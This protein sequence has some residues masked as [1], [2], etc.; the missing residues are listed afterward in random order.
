MP[1]DLICLMC[2]NGCHLKID[3][4][5]D[6][7]VHVT[8][9]RCDKGLAFAQSVLEHDGVKAAEGKMAGEAP[10]AAGEDVLG[11]VAAFWG[12]A[13]ARVHPDMI[14]AG[15]PERTLFRAVIEDREGRR[16][17]LEQI[18]PAS[19]Q[20][21]MRIVKTLEFL[22]RR[23][24]PRITPYWTN[25]QG[26]YLQKYDNTLW[27]MVPFVVGEPLDRGKYLFEGWRAKVLAQFLM[28]LKEKSEGIPFFALEKKFSVPDYIALLLRQIETRAP[29]LMPRITPV[30]AFLEKEFFPA[31]D[32]LPVAFCHGDYHPMNI[33]WGKDD[34]RTVIDWEF[35]GMKPEMYDLANMTGCL[36]VEDPESLVGDLV[37]GLIARLRAAGLFSPLSFAHFPEFVIALRFAWLSEWLRKD[38]REMIALE[39]DY[40]ELLI[41][42]RAG[43]ARAWGF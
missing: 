2:P 3:I 41:E 28:D 27:Q 5:D 38:D 21:K 42:N 24:M 6:Q 17:V 18:P 1:R 39:L 35:L 26:Q 23:G 8:G 31:Y 15:S 11:K 20:T 19:F 40:M 37:P 4:E 25:A 14:P 16:F 32:A 30:V 7:S 34:I 22:S 33:I 9:N 13:F 10:K 12:V 36:G 29:A 43:L